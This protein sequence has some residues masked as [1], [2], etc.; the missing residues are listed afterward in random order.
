MNNNQPAKP[1][2]AELIEIFGKEDLVTI[3]RE[4]I[5]EFKQPL[6]PEYSPKQRNYLIARMGSEDA[7]R[8]ISLRE[9][10][11]NNT[12][13]A[14]LAHWCKLYLRVTKPEHMSSSRLSDAAVEQAREYETWTLYEGRLIPSGRNFRALCPFHEERTPSFFFYSDGSYHCF[15][16]A[17]HGNNALDY[18]MNTEKVP[19]R[20]AVRRLA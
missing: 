19:F 9:A 17:A 2:F 13:K 6:R 15:S 8:I 18:L 20:D 4:K 12:R 5:E 10:I 11:R 14:E 3:F 1:T 16:C 7:V